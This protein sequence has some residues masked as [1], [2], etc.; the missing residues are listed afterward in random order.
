MN[1]PPPEVY[2]LVDRMAAAFMRNDIRYARELAD[3][4]RNDCAR[5]GRDEVRQE[6]RRQAEDQMEWHR[7]AD[8]WFV[9]KDGLKT[10]DRIKSAVGYYPPCWQ[11]ACR[12][13]PSDF[14][15]ATA[16]PCNFEPIEVRTYRCDGCGKDGLP[17]YQEV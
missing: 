1:T 9:T 5:E 12:K 7:E 16:A 8:A 17:I 14:V 10:K 11:R 3:D 15:T 6:L 13:A 2:T 4:F